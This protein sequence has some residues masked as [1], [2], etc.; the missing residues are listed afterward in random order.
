MSTELFSQ[1]DE[2]LRHLELLSGTHHTPPVEVTS[3]DHKALKAEI[4]SL[5]SALSATRGE[6]TARTANPVTRTDLAAVKRQTIDAVVPAVG[7]AILTAKKQSDLALK[8]TLGAVRDEVQ[9]VRNAASA[10]AQ[11]S[12]DFL[13]AA[14]SHF[15]RG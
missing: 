7:D 2:R 15:A 11:H 13:R 8:S 9:A 5:K 14:A 1:I 10:S 6:L 3:A 4:E 12:A